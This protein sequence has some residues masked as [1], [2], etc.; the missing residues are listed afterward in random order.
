ME[1]L[2]N[3]YKLK[4]EEDLKPYINYNN[5]GCLY[6][7]NNLFKDKENN[8]YLFNPHNNKYKIIKP[9]FIND[10][11]YIVVDDINNNKIKILI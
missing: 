6:I 2:L 3:K 4:D 10:I 5:K 1:Q 9:K 7:F 8:F 11:K